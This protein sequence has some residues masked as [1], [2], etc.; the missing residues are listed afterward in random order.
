MCLL[1]WKRTALLG[2]LMLV[3]GPR[4]PVCCVV[5]DL[6]QAGDRLHFGQVMHLI[7]GC[8]TEIVGKCWPLEVIFVDGRNVQRLDL[9]SLQ[10]SAGLPLAVLSTSDHWGLLAVRKGQVTVFRVRLDQFLCSRRL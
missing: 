10:A 5:R 6:R 7:V 1:G 3:S 4:V 9:L 8:L 2:V